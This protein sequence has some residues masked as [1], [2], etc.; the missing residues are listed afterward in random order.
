MAENKIS[1]RTLFIKTLG[2]SIALAF[3]MQAAHSATRAVLSLLTGLADP[4]A[5]TLIAAIG[6]LISKTAWSV[7]VCEGLVFATIFARRLWLVA[8]LVAGIGA[9]SAAFVGAYLR[10][11][12]ENLFFAAAFNVNAALNASVLLS[13]KYVFVAPALA[14]AKRRGQSLRDYFAAGGAASFIAALITLFAPSGGNYIA[15]GG[16]IAVDILF[17]LGCASVVWKMNQLTESVRAQQQFAREA[18]KNI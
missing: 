8:I 16:M 1:L 13:S 17:P 10:G 15:R 18:L 5:G 12:F 3:A 2:Y 14:W 4:E 6:E 11:A 9:L 7:V